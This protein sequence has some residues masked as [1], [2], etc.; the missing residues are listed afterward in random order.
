M[1]DTPVRCATCGFLARW[2]HDREEHVEVLEGGR[3]RWG[4]ALWHPPSTPWTADVAKEVAGHG[5][6]CFV[7]ATSLKE[8][9]IE[10]K[11]PDKI[12]AKERQCGRHFTWIL[13]HSPKEHFA[14]HMLDAARERDQKWQAE[15]RERDAQRA[16]DQRESDRKWQAEQKRLDEQQHEER[17]QAD[18]KWREEQ[19][20]KNQ[21]FQIEQN[22][23]N[24]TWQLRVALVAALIGIGG[25]LIGIF[26]KPPQPIIIERPAAEK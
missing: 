24:R 5:P 9:S 17:V 15:Q 10:A 21:A 19:D 8:E 11:D 7:M 23:R 25:V 6:I 2:D 3:K 12:I 1:S 18:R 13:G 26:A 4:L 20:V 14:M 22:A 16:A